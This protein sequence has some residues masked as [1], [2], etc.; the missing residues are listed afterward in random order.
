MPVDP[1]SVASSS[2]SAAWVAEVGK[3]KFEDVFD[4]TLAASAKQINSWLA[5]VASASA[6]ATATAA[7]GPAGAGAVRV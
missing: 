2:A 7:A 3:C 6:A 4:A 1:K 5:K